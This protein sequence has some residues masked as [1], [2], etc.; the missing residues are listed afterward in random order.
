MQRLL[1]VIT[2]LFAGT[3]LAEEPNNP[4]EGKWYLSPGVVAYEGPESRR[5]GHDDMDLGPGLI[6]GYSFSERWSVEFLGSQVES[7]FDTIFGSGDD[8]VTLTWLDALYK[9][10][11][12]S[13]WQP[14]LLFGGG[15]T[16]YEYDGARGHSKDRQFNAGFGVFR[17]L[18]EHISLRADVRGVSSR[19]D[20]GLQPFAFVGLTGFIGEGSGAGAP[21]D[22]DGDGVPNDQDQ[23]PTTP[24]GRLVDAV[25]CQLDS[26]G[27]GVVDAEDECPGTPPG[28]TVNPQGCVTTGDADG[29]GVPDDE[30]QCPDTEAGARV[31]ETGCYIVLE[32]EVTIDMN[33]EFDTDK[34]AIKPEHL[35]ELS[36][37]VNFL[38]RYPE[39]QAVI[40]GHT[41]SDGSAAY[42]QGL[43]ERRAKAVYSY[44]IDEAGIEAGRLSSAGFGESQPIADNNTADG[45]QR[46]RRV[47]AVVS[48]THKV[49]Q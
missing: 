19:K 34:A 41:D 26:D 2:L 17:E 37:A 43:S 38:R 13:D 10:D 1:A 33:I 29:D 20:G 22:S 36:R 32:E 3:A 35:E 46:N 15:R 23:C 31:D 7:D 47:S 14:F 4:T 42:N 28:A 45:K 6:V 48:G 40:E 9:L 12:N 18:T 30:D 16:K 27:D 5:R 44:L 25:G 21:A 39:T 11:S 49:R 24:P 8:D